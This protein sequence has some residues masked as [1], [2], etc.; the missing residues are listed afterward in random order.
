M[1]YLLFSGLVFKEVP[2]PY[3][4]REIAHQFLFVN[5]SWIFWYSTLSE[6]TRFWE[7]SVNYEIFHHLCLFCENLYP[8]YQS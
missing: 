8:I 7:D 1:G 2:T 4:A 6:E 3:L 5:V